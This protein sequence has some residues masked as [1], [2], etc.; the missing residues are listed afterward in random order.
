MIVHG[1]HIDAKHCG[2]VADALRLGLD[3]QWRTSVAPMPE[4][5]HRLLNELDAVAVNRPLPIKWVGTS[6]AARL[7]GVSE[8]WVRQRCVDGFYSGA[9]KHGHGWEIPASAVRP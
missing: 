3:A 8:R 7:L 1:V 4:V 9:R 2:A 6:D 5:L